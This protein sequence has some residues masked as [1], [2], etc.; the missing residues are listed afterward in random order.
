MS[1]PQR[2]VFAVLN[3]DFGSLGE[4]VY[5]LS[6]C[7]APHHFFVPSRLFPFCDVAGQLSRY[8]TL[9]EVESAI[10]AERPRFILL[11]SAYLLQVEAPSGD[12]GLRRLLACAAELEIPVA[13]TDPFYTYWIDRPW[14][15]PSP[16]EALPDPFVQKIEELSQRLDFVRRLPHVLPHPPRSD[17][18]LCHG[19][20]PP[21]C[22][23]SP[24]SISEFRVRTQRELADTAPLWLFFLGEVDL[25]RL[26]KNASEL[27]E[28]LCMRVR[29]G[30]LAGRH[31]HMVAPERLASALNAVFRRIDGFS[32][33]AFCTFSRFHQLMMAAELVFSWHQ[34]AFSLTHRYRH[35][36]P[37]IFFDRGHMI[38]LPGLH[39]RIQ[40]HFFAG[41][42]ILFA[43]YTRPLDAAKLLQHAVRQEQQMTAPYLAALR[44]LAC[45]EDVISAI[46]VASHG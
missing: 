18:P 5:F 34:F 27:F 35:G 13:T 15:S 42:Q 40:R 44:P 12:L 17:S 45:P 21:G 29:E 2:T 36:L 22:I 32:C 19:Y 3:K 11:A 30:L 1:D 39:E 38:E 33:D 24:E 4:A 16:G 41:C 8:D 28:N 25:Q 10:R 14:L 20:F 46:P 31:V 6:G 26:E 43:P 23:D 37:V 7:A 9:A